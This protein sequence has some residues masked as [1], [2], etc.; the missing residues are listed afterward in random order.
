M[1]HKVVV[2]LGWRGQDCGVLDSLDIQSDFS[3]YWV[4]PNKPNQYECMNNASILR[5]MEVHNSRQNFIYGKDYGYFDEFMEA[6]SK[7]L[8]SSTKTADKGYCLPV[9]WQNNTIV[10][11][12]SMNQHIFQS[13]LNILNIIDNFFK[14]QKW[15]ISSPY[16]A[17]NYD[18]ILKSCL[19]FFRAERI[20][21]FM[22]QIPNNETDALLLGLALE[23]RERLNGVTLDNKV[24]ENIKNLYETLEYR[25]VF[26]ETFW[27]ILQYLID[28]RSETWPCDNIVDV[29][30][31][32]DNHLI[33]YTRSIPVDNIKSL[34]NCLELL[35]FF[36]PTCSISRKEEVFNIIKRKLENQINSIKL[37]DDS[38]EIQVSSL[39]QDEFDILKDYILKNIDITEEGQNC[40]KGKW[41][42]VC[43]KKMPHADV[44]TEMLIANTLYDV[45]CQHAKQNTSKYLELSSIPYSEYVPLKISQILN[46]FK[47]NDYSGLFIIGSSGCGKTSSLKRFIKTE[48]SNGN[49][50]IP[51]AAVMCN[52]HLNHSNPFFEEIFPEMNEDILSQLHDSCKQRNNHIFFLIDG[53]NEFSGTNAGAIEIYQ[54]VVNFCTTI[55]KEHFYN[56]KVIISCRAGSFFYY[57][58]Q[59]KMCPGLNE[60]MNFIENE[61]LD[62]VPYYRAKALSKDEINN[63]CNAYFE[64]NEKKRLFLNF[65]ESENYDANLISPFFIA[66]ASTLS[67]DAFCSPQKNDLFETYITKMLVN[68]GSNLDLIMV[69]RIFDVYFKHFLQTKYPIN[70][71]YLV[72]EFDMTEQKKVLDI[73]RKLAEVNLIQFHEDLMSDVFRFSHDKI[74]E[75]FLLLFLKTEIYS[76]NIIK[77]F[78]LIQRNVIFK[79]SC[80]YFFKYMFEK[81]RQEIVLVFSKIYSEHPDNLSDI[82]GK[83]F[84]IC[85]TSVIENFLNIGP[86]VLEIIQS[87][88][89][90]ILCSIKSYDY[91]V[92]I[93]NIKF[94]IT[95]EDKYPY[96][97]SMIPFFRYIIALYHIY[98][99]INYTEAERQTQ[100]AFKELNTDVLSDKGYLI[101]SFRVISAIVLR[102]RGHIGQAEKLLA[103]SKQYFQQYDQMEEFYY[104]TLELGSVL[105]EQTNF[106][107]AVDLYEKVDI[108]KISRH[109]VLHQRLILQA[110][111]IYKN[112]MQELLYSFNEDESKKE[113]A[114]IYREKAIQNF[115]EI[116]NWNNCKELILIEAKTE[117]AETLIF[118]SQI[119]SSNFYIKELLDNIQVLLKNINAPHRILQFMRIEA[120]YCEIEK[121]VGMA[122]D[123]LCEAKGIAEKYELPFRVFE[124]NYQIAHMIANQ[125]GHCSAKLIKKGMK[126]INAAIYF[127]ETEINGST[128]LKECLYCREK[129]EN[130]KI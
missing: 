60:F 15:K 125:S 31:M 88:V 107:K 29:R 118:S 93:E 32:P 72:Q 56:F 18:D 23:L 112:K 115:K 8:L 12:I 11:M 51:L 28:P 54:F 38:I 63:L 114:L 50:C 46:E 110:G 84:Q 53:L 82:L 39:A 41:I 106:D 79:K 59:S 43:S 45:V 27:K 90:G 77:A 116:I 124:C 30:F 92:N 74:E 120:N 108:D 67:S 40:L 4:S 9:V 21:S 5:W 73:L 55:N 1:T 96:L 100:I 2:L 103:E 17:K 71:F 20:P 33:L 62:P 75:Y 76:N 58:D 19:L 121:N 35:T 98:L 104:I 80:I 6:L 122:L 34:I 13:F 14:K 94:I 47:H 109:P 97:K 129:L 89:Y 123:I 87:A 49:I 36:A 42:T 68:V 57:M 85:E 65:I 61:S 91:S 111:I 78:E 99:T 66:I 10:D 101:Y 64:N 25:C 83:A 26:N 126:A 113:K 81:K 86:D 69:Y 37:L 44:D 117:L 70:Y 127:C 3:C 7:K 48:V 128:Y 52:L 105:R 130:I 119:V 22:L 95:Q 102:N 16:Y 24:L